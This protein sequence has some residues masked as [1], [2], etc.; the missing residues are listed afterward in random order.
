MYRRAVV[1]MPTGGLADLLADGRGLV[2]SSQDVRWFVGAVQQ[3][4]AS[5]ALAED[6]GQRLHE[7]VRTHHNVDVIAPLWL[8]AVSQAAG[9]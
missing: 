2:G 4:L 1:A 8:Q 5:R 3:V 7:F 6:L 9:R